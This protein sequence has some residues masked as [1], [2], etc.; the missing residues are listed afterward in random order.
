MQKYTWTDLHRIGTGLS[1]ADDTEWQAVQYDSTRMRGR[2]QFLA[3]YETLLRGR[4]ILTSCKNYLANRDSYHGGPKV[5]TTHRPLH[6]TTRHSSHPMKQN[7]TMPTNKGSEDE[8][9]IINEDATNKRQWGGTL[10]GWSLLHRGRTIRPCLL[11]ATNTTTNQ[12]TH[13]T[14]EKQRL[15]T[16]I[17]WTLYQTTTMCQ[18]LS[19]HV[20]TKI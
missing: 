15:I 9:F 16:L 12:E 14:V 10:V 18:K 19:H 11:Q 20:H 13:L 8:R 6:G 1:T 4:G 3:F 7:N 17:R 5:I 2:M